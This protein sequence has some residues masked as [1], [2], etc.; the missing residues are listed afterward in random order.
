L[1]VKVSDGKGWPADIILPRS[2]MRKAADDGILVDFTRHRVL[3][4][5]KVATPY[6]CWSP[7]ARQ[8]GDVSRFGKLLFKAEETKNLLANPDFI[9]ENI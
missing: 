8:F 1:A 5:I 9:P 3:N 6:Y 2:S 4:G 7:F